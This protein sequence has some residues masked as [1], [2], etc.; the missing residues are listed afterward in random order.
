MLVLENNKVFPDLPE[1]NCCPFFAI[2][3]KK[4]I[5]KTPKLI[6]LN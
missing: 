3:K 6:V 5:L 4:K 1:I 2:K